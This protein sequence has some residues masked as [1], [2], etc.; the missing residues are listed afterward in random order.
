MEKQVKILIV[1]HDATDIELLLHHLKKNDFPHVAEVVETEEQYIAA[2]EEFKPDIILSDFSLPAFNGL[3]A[4]EI[5]QQMAPYTPFI[6]V[7]GTIGDENAVDLIKNGITDY[8]LKD[9][10]YSLLPKIHRAM[11]EACELKK[12]N[13]AEALLR[14]NRSLLYEAQSIAH[15]G[16]WEIDLITK[17]AIWSDEAYR[18]LGLDPA[19]ATPSTKLFLQ[20]VHPDDLQVVERAIGLAMEN[21]QSS[22]YSC[23]VISADKCEKYIHVQS[24]FALNEQGLPIRIFG[25]VH[26]ITELKRAEM[27]IRTMNSALEEKVRQRTSELLD[28][29]QQLEAFTYSVSHDLRTPL[30]SIYGFAQII[31]KSVRDKLD[32]ADQELF[33][34]IMENT[35]RMQSLIE[36]MLVFSRAGRSSLKKVRLDMKEVVGSC[37]ASVCENMKQKPEIKMGELP[38]VFADKSLIEQVLINLIANAVKYSSKNPKPEILIGSKEEG[39][40]IVFYI[41]DNGA[42]FDM[43]YYG[44]LFQVFSRLHTLDEFEGTGVGLAIVKRIIE[45]HGGQVWAEGR[46]G[47][48]ATFY[49]KLPRTKKIVQPQN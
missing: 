13:E 39:E 27:E 41:K 42:G 10:L 46:L 32:T 20:F 34:M 12:K 37:I 44:R 45:K 33:D 6:I 22:V 1:E 15:L 40:T 2:L 5:K 11:K 17:K 38:Q 47:E 35:L 31:K 24:K 26:D 8:A 3:I 28:S 49:F 43:Q 9:K 48:G 25:T 29:N 18:I 30:R 16:N 21:F 23:R 7:S 36:D 14:K 4:F 19:Q